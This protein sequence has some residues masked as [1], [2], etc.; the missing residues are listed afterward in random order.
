MKWMIEAGLL[1]ILAIEDVRERKISVAWLVL[2]A[3]AGGME[4]L[5]PDLPGMEDLLL[6]ERLTGVLPGLVLL[7]VSVFAD[8]QIGMGDGIA[9]A[10]LGFCLGFG[11]I[12]AVLF[13]SCI[14]MGIV[15]ATLLGTGKV[16]KDTSLPHLLFLA[17]G[18][19]IFLLTVL[20][21]CGN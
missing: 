9:V 13:Y 6:Q 21:G 15:A 18:Y 7:A 4:I 14:S 12:M 8:G 2:M 5:L 16:S 20:L 10:C 3:A 11:A 1:V 19:G 17:L